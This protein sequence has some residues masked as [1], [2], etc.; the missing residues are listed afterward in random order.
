MTE[1]E[2]LIREVAS[3][4]CRTEG[5]HPL[6]PGYKVI[7]SASGTGIIKFNKYCWMDYIPHAK[8]VLS[9]IKDWNNMSRLEQEN[10]TPGTELPKK[11]VSYEI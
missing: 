7:P 3:A 5:L 9:A 4:I 2:M 10:H 11:D 8:A 1:K 6:N